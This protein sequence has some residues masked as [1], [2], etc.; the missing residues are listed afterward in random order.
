M[1]SVANASNQVTKDKEDLAEKLAKADEARTKLA[2]S[3]K[4]LQKEV[5]T[6]KR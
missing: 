1:K 3:E 4:N 5:E 2:E 6:L